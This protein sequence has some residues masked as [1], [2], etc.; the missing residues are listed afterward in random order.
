LLY[1][2]EV[3]GLDRVLELANSPHVSKLTIVTLNHDTLIEQLLTSNQIHYTDGFGNPD[4]DVKWF[5]DAFSDDT[6]I[7]LIKLHGSIS[8]WGQ[9]GDKVLQPVN[10]TDNNPTI[11]KNNKNELIE[12]IRSVPSFLTGVS[13]VYSYNRGVFA[14]QNYRFL[15]ALHSDNM[16]IMSGY[17]WGDIP[18]NFQLQNWLNR[19]KKNNLILLH[20]DPT[21]LADKSLELRHIYNKY[22]TRGQIIPI[23]KWLSETPLTEIQGFIR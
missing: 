8:W 3:K 11:W 15:Q 14:D 7:R 4:G 6:K 22:T 1:T 9:G 23:E 2:T 21:D 13:K 17:G 5:E 18:I 19:N 10:I 20:R 12:D 16:M